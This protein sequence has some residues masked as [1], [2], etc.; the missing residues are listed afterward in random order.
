M[1]DTGGEREG[2]SFTHPA[3]FILVGSMNPEEGDLRPQ[4][5][6]RFAL[7]VD[8]RGIHDPAERM[9]IVERHI[10]YETDPE[11]FRESWSDEEERL[12]ERISAAREIVDDVDYSKRDL[13]SIAS[14]T[15]NLHALSAHIVVEDDCFSDGHTPQLLDRIQACLADHFDVEHSTF[16]FEPASHA[17]HESGTH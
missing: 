12:S 5:L 7:S 15:S 6:D 1:A 3:R 16:Q 11:E 9:E 17:A 10:G 8:V 13:F 4:L 2:I 14:L